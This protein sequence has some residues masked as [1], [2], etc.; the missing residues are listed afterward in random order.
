[1]SLSVGSTEP[2]GLSKVARQVDEIADGDQAIVIDITRRQL[3]VPLKLGGESDEVADSKLLPSR[4]HI[5]DVGVATKSSSPIQAL[6]PPE[7]RY[8]RGPLRAIVVA[9]SAQP[10]ALPASKLTSR[11]RWRIRF[12]LIASWS[13]DRRVDDQRIVFEIDCCSPAH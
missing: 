11:A 4:L 7:N 2:A 5:A 10:N 8:S 12:D 6:A 13:Q 1:M 9:N 3:P